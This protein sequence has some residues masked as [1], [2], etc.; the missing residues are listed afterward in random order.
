MKSDDRPQDGGRRR[1][2]AG[3]VV[4]GAGAA[5]AAA[6]PGSALADRGSG[7]P[8]QAATGYR[9]SQH[10][11]DYYKSTTSQGNRR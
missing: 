6:V 10:V 8:Q 2:L 7:Q 11:L 9:L 3:S 5:V 1:F 4:A